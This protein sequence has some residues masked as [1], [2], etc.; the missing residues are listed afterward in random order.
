MIR[1]DP[2]PM[3]EARRRSGDCEVSDVA[4]SSGRHRRVSKNFVE[5]NIQKSQLKIYLRPMDYNDPEGRVMKVPQSFGWTLDRQV[6]VKNAAD[7]PYVMDF[8]TQ[9][10]ENVI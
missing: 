1:H 7:L 4:V 8:I 10:Y 2:S 6:L 3:H 5:F 9:S